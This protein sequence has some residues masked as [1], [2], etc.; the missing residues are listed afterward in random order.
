M[1]WLIQEKGLWKLGFRW[2]G[3]LYKRSLKTT[4]EEQANILL[5]RVNA[6]LHDV[7]LGRLEPPEGADLLAFLLTD[8]RKVTTKP[9]RVVTLGK[10]LE[11][12][13]E[14]VPEGSK[15]KSSIYTEKIH[16][17]H[18]K[19][20]LGENVPVRSL[21][22][23]HLQDYVNRRA[24]QTG[25]R[26]HKVKPDTIR[27]EINTL[28]MIWRRAAKK[29]VV[30][31]PLPVEGLLYP[32]GVAKEPFRT[33]A[34][35]EQQIR[36]ESLEDNLAA[37]LWDSVYLRLAEIED[38]L[39]HVKAKHGDE[40][41]Y[42][43]MCFVAYTGAR[44]SEVL[45]SR[46]DDFDFEGM[47]VRVRE[48]KKDKNKTT[49]RVVPLV[50]QLASVMKA[51]FDGRHPGGALT[52]CEDKNVPLTPQNAHHR[53]EEAILGSKW[54]GKLRGWHVFRHSFASNCAAQ[55]IDQR[56]ID[57]WMG[58]QTEQMRRRY[59]HLFPDDQNKALVALFGQPV[60]A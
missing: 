31:G 42:P 17:K 33:V 24:K 11:E 59:Q 21:G 3:K 58:H 46:V 10:L 19:E 53:F 55:G 36:R 2:A 29:G 16:V 25:R 57:A 45:R 7:E 22:L 56:N 47:T 26:K 13:I 6:N 44:R 18:L 54:K 1:A 4:S 15:E 52:I 9:Q 14:S 30:P 12:Y 23:S 28:A 20:C 40:A 41:M 34:E 50:P 48:K 32:K 35:I 5:G 27:K 8:G 37:E 43:M 38:V 39:A 51:W 49:I 60:Q